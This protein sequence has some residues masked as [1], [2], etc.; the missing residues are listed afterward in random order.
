VRLLI[1]EDERRLG[2]RLAQGLRED[3]FAVDLAHDLASARD[4]AIV[5]AHD[6]VLLDL[7]LPDGSGLDLLREWRDEGKIAPVLV[8]TS[9]DTLEDKVA[10]LDAGADDYLTKPFELAELLA[11][12]RALL[13]RRAV[14]PRSVLEAGALRLDRDA[15]R[16]TVRGEALPLT[17]KE[18]ALLEQFLLRPGVA[19]S[20]ETLAEHVWDE[21][22]EARSNVIDVLVGRLRRKLDA[23]QAAARLRAVVGVGWALDASADPDREPS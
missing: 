1:V 7:N 23:A 20:R 16:A 5:G 11:R 6:L 22:Y 19:V 13:R 9:R 15:R 17:L 2:A 4:L 21:S 10:G 3:G 18:L 8:L 12:V 14:P